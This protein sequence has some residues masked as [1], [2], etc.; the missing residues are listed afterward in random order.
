MAP[1]T[2]DK[3]F[4]FSPYISKQSSSRRLREDELFVSAIRQ[5]STIAN[6]QSINSLH[7]FLLLRTG[8]TS[9]LHFLLMMGSSGK[10]GNGLL[11]LAIYN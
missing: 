8:K 1:F 7:A 6:K 2:Y 5:L 3:L 4:G 11:F 10:S 9:E